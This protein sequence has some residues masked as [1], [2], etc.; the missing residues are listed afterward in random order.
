MHATSVQEP[1]TRLLVG[2]QRLELKLDVL[3]ATHIARAAEQEIRKFPRSST[4]LERH[5]EPDRR[6]SS[7]TFRVSTS[8]IRSQ[9]ADNCVC[10]CHQW[11]KRR[12]P[13]FLEQFFSILFVGYTGLPCLTQT[14][15]SK[16][17]GTRS[18]PTLVITYLF[19]G[20]LLARAIFLS[21]RYTPLQGPELIIRVPRL[22]SHGARIFTEL[23][24]GN[25]DGT[26]DLLRRGLA[27]PID[28]SALNGESA[29]MVRRVIP[30]VHSND[31]TD[32]VLLVC[33][34]I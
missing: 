14:C 32:Y 33:C 31:C 26:K 11:H 27:S 12:G 24:R 29:L 34:R 22:V 2:Q 1:I 4:S 7:T 3:E 6:F 19:P 18:A 13:R 15:D 28:T 21:M 5:P 16:S 10:I 25:I 23:G 8:F 9:C 30:L 20:W 17:C